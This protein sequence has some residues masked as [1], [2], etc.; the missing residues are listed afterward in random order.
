MSV[1]VSAIKTAYDALGT[2]VT[3]TK[4]AAQ[5]IVD[6]GSRPA[7][8][9]YVVA[10]ADYNSVTTAITT[11]DAAMVTARATYSTALAAQV[12]QEVITIALMPVSEWIKLT[13]LANW[14]AA[15][16]QYIGIKTNATSNA[17][18]A[19][20]ATLIYIVT[21]AAAPTKPFPNV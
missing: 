11:Y 1:S 9:N 2:L 7:Y 4:A 5:A 3:T 8:P 14:G 15:T 16:T 12:A 17:D 18:N 19:S 13:T 20:G 6:L 10:D 21:N